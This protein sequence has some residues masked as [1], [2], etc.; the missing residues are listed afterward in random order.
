MKPPDQLRI[1]HRKLEAFFAWQKKEQKRVDREWSQ[2][3][4]T[5]EEGAVIADRQTDRLSREIERL[6]C[7]AEVQ[8]HYMRGARLKDD[9][10]TGT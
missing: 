3:D 9:D 1:N 7:E 5:P 4:G 8:A 2:F 10:R 6:D